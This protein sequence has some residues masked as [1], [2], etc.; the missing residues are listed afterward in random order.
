M[1][2]GLF[3]LLAPG[4]LPLITTGKTCCLWLPPFL[5]PP[6]QLRVKRRPA[7]RRTARM[8]AAPAGP[9]AHLAHVRRRDG[10][11]AA[12]ARERLAQAHERL[13]LAHGD[14]VAAGAAGRRVLR[15]QPLVG[16]H[17]HALRLRARARAASGRPR[18]R[19]G[20]APC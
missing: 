19:A 2:G 9:G 15:A 8:A 13:Q 12:Q 16:V 5:R 1:L 10:L 4:S 6:H 20:R 3:E 11:R 14:A 17:Q 18:R 7:L